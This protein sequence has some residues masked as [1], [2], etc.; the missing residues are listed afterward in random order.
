M[1]FNTVSV[2]LIQNKHSAITVLSQKLETANATATTAAT[3]ATA[4]TT[5]NV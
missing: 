5:T 3:A 2:K 4:A 1:E